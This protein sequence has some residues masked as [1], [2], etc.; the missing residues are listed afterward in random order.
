MYYAGQ[1]GIAGAVG[2]LAGVNPPIRGGAS[3]G[4]PLLPNQK[5]LK[6]ISVILAFLRKK[7][8]RYAFLWQA[9]WFR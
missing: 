1:S 9:S 7:L 3:M 8:F 5:E 6:G 2:N 4:R